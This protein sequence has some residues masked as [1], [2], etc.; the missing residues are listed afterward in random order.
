MLD[1][2]QMNITINSD[3]M[4][5]SNKKILVFGTSYN[6]LRVMSGLAGLAFIE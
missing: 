5:N 3:Y 6:I 1:K 2:V 4:S